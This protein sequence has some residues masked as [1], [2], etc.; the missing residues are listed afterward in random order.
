MYLQKTQLIMATTKLFFL[1]LI[2]FAA[3]A[4]F[5]A[6]LSV[7]PGTGV[8][9]AGQTF[10]ARVV[11]NTSGANIN[12]AEGVISF[13]PG[14]LSVVGISKGSIF[15]LWT[16][17]PSF[18]NSAGTIS[19]SGG[20]PSGYKG[21]SGTVI[22]VTFR[23]KG[24]GNPR[25]SFSSGAV[26]AADG[27]GTN[28]LSSMNGGS[29]TVASA[30]VIP[31]P[32]TIEYIAPANTP[33]APTITSTTHD[34]MD[35]YHS[36]T[37]AE[38]AWTLP[39]GVVAVRTLLD[40]QSGTIP[41]K[42]YDDPISSITIDE[43]EEGVQYFHMQ[44]KNVDGWGRVTHY[45]LAVD[46]AAPSVFDIALNEGADLSNPVQTLVLT[47]EDET[48]KVERFLIQIDAGE[49]YEFIDTED[50]GAVTLPSLEPG[51]HSVII[52][53]F[54]EAGNSLISSFSFGVLAFDKPQFTEFPAEVSANV[55]P[56]I[57]GIT[58]PN[59]EVHLKVMKLG[60]DA[61][62]LTILSGENGEFIY[63]P[64]G[65]FSLGV[66]EISAVAIDQYGAQSEVSEA[67]R[68]AVQEPG[69]L[70]VG[71]IAV[72]VLSVLVPVIALLSL[73]IFF[74]W[75]L[76]GR[77]RKLRRRV[78]R[79][80]REAMSMLHSEFGAL[81]TLIAEQSGALAES[82]KNKKLTKAEAELIDSVMLKLEESQKKVAKEITDVEDIVD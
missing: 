68:I 52:E 19:F 71:S 1:A 35:A 14:E 32:E 24:A 15:N 6:T 39:S 29:F 3:Q 8:Y 25:L 17:E 36:A 75:F 18:S 30:A 73:T 11:V 80:A 61:Q 42:V 77:L 55:I 12:A 65:R 70:R 79:E 49:P 78:S 46:T 57:K 47:T 31:E 63:I 62:E 16:A 51:H 59:S 45:R 9:T 23:T 5:A 26:L 56:V 74:L 33:V 72:S 2:L 41:T 66:Y 58:R 38:L 28:V 21:G 76:W 50:I 53:A 7:S 43:L 67:V 64:E 40:T 4:T 34:D 37:T 82:R 27:R 54:D 60:S 13:K 22:S 10:T 69:Y 48:S 81:K 44:F 20:T